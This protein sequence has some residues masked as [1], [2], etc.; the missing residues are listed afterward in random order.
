MRRGR[1]GNWHRAALDLRKAG[2]W[3][4]EGNLEIVNIPTE[5]LEEL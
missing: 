5:V 4:L 2:I 3:R 1:R